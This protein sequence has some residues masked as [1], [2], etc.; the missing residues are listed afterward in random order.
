LFWH[1]DLIERL[2]AVLQQQEISPR[3]ESDDQINAKVFEEQRLRPWSVLHAEYEQ[4]HTRLIKLAEQLSEEDMTDSSRFAAV[5][6][7]NP[8]FTAFIGGCYEHDQEH[9]AQYYLDHHNLPW[10]IEV[11]EKCASRV[12]QADVPG[13]VKGWFLYNLAGFYAEQKL[14]EKA[15]ARLQEA[16]IQSPSLKENAESNPDLSALLA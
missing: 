15:A 9:L 4:A 5:T 11:R 14:P 6:E 7:G 1:Q 10:A 2:T 16:L 8:L 13:W 12:V 3:E